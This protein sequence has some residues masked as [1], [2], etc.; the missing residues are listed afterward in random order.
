MWSGHHAP[1]SRLVKAARQ[2]KLGDG[3]SRDRRRQDGLHD[4]A[5]PWKLG[6]PIP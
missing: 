4:P 6:I 1:A 3:S 2:V 5:S